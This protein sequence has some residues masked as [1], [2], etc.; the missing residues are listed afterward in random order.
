[1]R[2]ANR[3]DILGAV[4]LGAGGLVASR[5]LA[6]N[7][8][9]DGHAAGYDVAPASNF[10][11]TIPRKDGDATAFKASL[12]SAP[13]K[14]TTGGWAR[15]I[16][17]RTLP[18]ATNIASARLFINPGG[19]REMHWHNS[20]EWAY[21]LGGHCQITIIDPEGK[22]EVANY[23]AGDLWFFPKGHAHAIQCLGSEDCHAVLA[24]D[25]G[26]Y[27]EH[28]TFGITDW[29]SRLDSALLA[30]TLGVSKDAFDKMPKAETYIMQGKVLPLD[31][32]QARAAK[33]AEHPH[34]HRYR[35]VAQKPMAKT[36]GGELYIA[37]AREF[38]MSSTMTGMLLKLK[39]GAMHEPHWHPNANE[40]IY[41]SKG[42]VRVALFEPEKRMAVTE[43]A[44]GDIA[45]IPQNAGHSVQN[46]GNED[47]EVIGAFDNGSYQ[48]IALADWVA[49][50][51]RHLLAN[52]FGVA[53]GDLASFRK[54]R[55]VIVAAT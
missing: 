1:M 55:G 17:A 29:M 45:Y 10:L 51:P 16:T 38:P 21:I 2:N 11:P 48:E 4:A 12:D 3:R 37:S 23:S 35:M 40:W 20:A 32:P 18:I 25:D 31:G 43:L 30:Q 49:K 8:A 47:A 26:L 44:V 28:G 5:S 19:C 34:S 53:E 14:A 15:E 46:V 27:G 7:G 54:Q 22:V 42:R 39:P 24:F 9:K 36:P 33:E 41:L 52:N 6:A 13:I 50:V